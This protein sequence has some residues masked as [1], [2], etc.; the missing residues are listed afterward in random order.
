MPAISLVVCLYRER[1]LLERLLQKCIGCY[2]NLV[3]VHDGPEADDGKTPQLTTAPPREMASDYSLLAPG[4]CVPSFY[5]TLALPPRANSIHQLVW[6]ENGQYFEGPHCYQQEPHWPFAWS[7]AKHDWI[8]RLDADEFPSEELKAWL[9]RFREGPEPPAGVSGYTCIWPLWNGRRLVTTQWPAGRIFLFHKQR[10]RFFGMVEQV[11]IPDVHYEP[12]DLVLHHRPKRKSYGVRNILFREQAYNWRHVIAHSLMSKPTAL[13][14][15][16]WH[17]AEWP[18]QWSWI[19][20][21]P[22]RYSIAS[23]IRFPLLQLS[24]MLNA[25]ETPSASACLN[26]GLHHFM[27]GLRVFVEKRRHRKRTS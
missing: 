14:C 18:D 26:P 15:W 8:L 13:P 11:P 10:V 4:A 23:F 6:Q 19:R 9:C 12:L 20:A 17:S 24:N 21:H 2:N 22:L 3:V 25:R 1:A 16:R 5:R 27:L 7:Q